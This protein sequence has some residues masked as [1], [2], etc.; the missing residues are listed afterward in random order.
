MFKDKAIKENK[1][2]VNVE[3]NESGCKGKMIM[4]GMKQW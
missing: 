1:E 4:K 3:E 2:Q